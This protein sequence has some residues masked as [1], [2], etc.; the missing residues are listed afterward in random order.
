MRGIG[1]LCNLYTKDAIIPYNNYTRP[2]IYFLF[3][4]EN[5]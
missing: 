5:A 4:V 3:H 1:I 2:K